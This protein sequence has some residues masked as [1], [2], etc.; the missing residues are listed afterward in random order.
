MFIEGD[1]QNSLLRYS[2]VS[3][4]LCYRY[5]SLLCLKKAVRPGFARVFGGFVVVVCCCCRPE[6]RFSSRRSHHYVCF[7]FSCLHSLR[8]MVLHCAGAR[9]G[10]WISEGTW[11]DQ[12]L[13][14][15]LQRKERAGSLGTFMRTLLSHNTP[16]WGRRSGG[17]VERLNSKD[18]GL[19]NPC[20]K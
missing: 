17:W 13:R 12:R 15:S 9:R 4:S 10:L 20:G 8:G 3:C 1:G 2:F 7:C 14:E 16:N 11:P 19:E 6:N 18:C 5:S